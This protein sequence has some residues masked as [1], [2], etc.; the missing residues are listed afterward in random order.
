[1][2][3]EIILPGVAVAGGLAGFLIRRW[4]L[5]TA[6]EPD[7]GLAIPHMPATY[8][9]LILCAGMALVLALLCRG[10]HSAFP[11]GYDQAFA[12]KGNT[13][14]I[15][16]M[17][18]SAFLLLG[19]AV[20]QV[21]ELPRAYQ[22][23]VASLTLSQGRGNPLLSV[24]PRAL[25]ALLCAASCFCVL[26]T[27]KN[28]YRGEGKGKYNFTLL[29]PAYT[30]CL[31]LVAAYQ[32]RASDPVILDYLYELFAII[33]ALLGLY[34]TA[35]FSFERPKVFRASFFSLLGVYFSFVTLADQHGTAALLLYGF[36]IL[37]LL[38]STAVLCYNAGRPDAP[39]PVEAPT[40]E[41]HETEEIHDES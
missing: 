13:L 7:T 41:D 39:R 4:E 26:S 15:T 25:L 10:K 40:P 11:G 36:V 27:G 21:L 18:L 9:L 2:R 17:V 32:Q 8:A 24:L 28:N 35:G 3:K 30:C 29:L 37:N 20:F 14:Y 22:E 16:A 33:A 6:F 1:M 38:C 19:A 31:W 12:A 23:A 5:A 34:F